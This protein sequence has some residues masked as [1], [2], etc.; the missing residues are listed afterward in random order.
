[1][2]IGFFGSIICLFIALCIVSIS[3]HIAIQFVKGL[4][5][6]LKGDKDE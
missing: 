5:K 6:K 2:V 1:M 4:I 3:L